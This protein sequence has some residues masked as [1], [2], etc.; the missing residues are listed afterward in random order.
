MDQPPASIVVTSFNDCINRRDIE[1]LA[2]LMTDDHVLI[3]SANTVTSGKQRCLAA[4]KGF[5][6]AFPDYRNHVERV[7]VAGTDAVIIGHSDCSDVRLAGPALWTAKVQ[8][9]LISEWRVYDDTEA[10]RT[11]L[12]VRNR[13]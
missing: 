2:K 7:L 6:D 1:G 3:D 13:S 5:F 8:G 4:W 10:N 12:G 9:P 11:L